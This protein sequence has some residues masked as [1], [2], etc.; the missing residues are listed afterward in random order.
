MTLVS[1]TKDL[2]LI[3]TI[4]ANDVDEMPNGYCYAVIRI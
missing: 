1:D 3:W 2:F 4:Y